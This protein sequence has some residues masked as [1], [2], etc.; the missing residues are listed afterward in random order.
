MPAQFQ[1]CRI[2]IQ[3]DV[4]ARGADTAL[5]R[6]V[7]V[8]GVLGEEC[9]QLGCSHVV[10]P[11]GAE[12]AH[13]L[14]RAFHLVPPVV[15]LRIFGRESLSLDDLAWRLQGDSTRGRRPPVSGMSAMY[16]TRQ[17]VPPLVAPDAA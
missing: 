2:C 11:G 4:P 8:N 10:G 9:G 6:D 1:S 13:Y 5:Q 16:A 14:D 12:P 15:S 7:L 17:L 3:R